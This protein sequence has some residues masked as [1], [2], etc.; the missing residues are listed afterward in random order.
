MT[1][2]RLAWATDIHLE[3]CDD[4]A[5]GGFLDNVAAAA[6]DALVL[7]GDIGQ[8]LS[9]S[10]FLR[11][12][13][14]GLQ[15]PIYFVLGNHDF[16]K[17]SI[18][19][20]RAEVGELTRSAE[21]LHWLRVTGVIGLTPSSALIGVDGWADGRFGDYA[22]SPVML[23]DYL[24]IQELSGIRA[25]ERLR[26]M[27]LLAGE[28]AAILEKN[29]RAALANHRRVVVATHVP[30]FA[31]SAWHEGK[32]S[33]GNWLPHFS[34]KACGDVLL[35]GADANADREILVLCGHTHGGGTVDVRPNLRVITGPAEYGAPGL[36]HIFELS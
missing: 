31:E 14:S 23:N 22:R 34:S 19:A 2:F 10:K 4:A 1:T 7:T 17:G 13:E 35:A 26:R 29:L 15:C 9:V 24:L 32:Q 16:Y 27:Q 12:I 28:D 3:F 11:R 18:A 20:A 8:A 6:P 5:I 36:Q 33:D 21:R 30:P 25:D